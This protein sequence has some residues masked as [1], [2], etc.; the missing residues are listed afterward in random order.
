MRPTANC[1]LCQKPFQ[2]GSGVYHGRRIPKWEGLMVC[3]PCD[4]AN[5][6]GVVPS[7]YPHFV[8]LLAELGIKPELNAQGWTVLPE[9]GSN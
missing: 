2:F 1:C 8:A 5:N 3:N 7:S 9:R 6:N 4:N